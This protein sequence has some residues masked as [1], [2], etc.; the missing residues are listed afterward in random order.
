LVESDEEDADE[1]NYDSQPS[2]NDLN[3]YAD[4]VKKTFTSELERMGFT[5][6]TPENV[7]GKTE[8]VTPTCTPRASL[9]NNV[10]DKLSYLDILALENLYPGSMNS[11]MALKEGEKMCY[12]GHCN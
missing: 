12:C 2:R 3:S 1:D 8:S 10:T 7:C 4:E 9:N 11:L 6:L 5:V